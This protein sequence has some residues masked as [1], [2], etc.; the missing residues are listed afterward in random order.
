MQEIP[1]PD[2]PDDHDHRHLLCRMA[3]EPSVQDIVDDAR[4]AGWSDR[5]V[6]SAIIEVAD[7]LMLESACDDDLKELLAVLKKRR[8]N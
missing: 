2:V 7:D 4:L 6:L 8:R 3:I 5:E 1:S